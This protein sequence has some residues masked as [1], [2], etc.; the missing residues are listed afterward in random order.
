MGAVDVQQQ[1]AGE[2]QKLSI[3]IV[4]ENSSRL[5]AMLGGQFDFTNQFPL[6]FIQQAQAA[7]T[8]QVQEAKPNFQLVYY[9]FKITR[10]MV[11]EARV[12]RP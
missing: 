11:S 2:I 9:G 3:K 8:L 1:G 6:Q 7:P 10:P 5:A 12:R 4:P